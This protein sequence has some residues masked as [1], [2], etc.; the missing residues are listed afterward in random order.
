MWRAKRASGIVLILAWSVLGVLP[1]GV[2]PVRA[3]PP[4]T[5]W[6]G[7]DA[8]DAAF[9]C[10]DRPA[11][12]E[13]T[14]NAVRVP[15]RD[16]GSPG[17]VY[18][19]CDLYRPALPG[20]GGTHYPN[21]PGL[22]HGT[23]TPAA[24]RFPGI[25]SYGAYALSHK[26]DDSPALRLF[27]HFAEHGY[28]VVNCDSRGT[29][30]SHATAPGQ[31]FEGPLSRT[32]QRDN[33]DLIEWMAEQEWS[34]GRIG[35]LGES[36]YAL[37]TDRVSGA[38]PP[39]LVTTFS[40]ASS[41]SIYFDL[42]Y[43]G[44][45]Y[46]ALC[47]AAGALPMAFSGGT[48]N[49]VPF[50]A[51]TATHPLYDGFWEQIDVMSK[52][53][54]IDIPVLQ[55]NGHMDWLFPGAALENYIGLKPH[56]RGPDAT[57]PW[58]I[59]DPS[60]HGIEEGLEWT[61]TGAPLA[62][63]DHWLM[64]L[65]TAPLPS[66]RATVYQ[67]PVAGADRWE[68]LDDWPPADVDRQRL[69]FTV[70]GG[71]SPDAGPQGEHQ[72]TVGPAD[73]VAG[74]ADNV[75]FTSEPLAED[76]AIAG[77]PQ[78]HLKAELTA[79]DG[80]FVVHLF[81]VDEE[82][83]ESLISGAPYF[84]KASHHVSHEYL[85]PITPGELSD[86]VIPGWQTSYRFEEGHRIRVI[87]SSNYGPAEEPQPRSCSSPSCVDMGVVRIRLGFLIEPAPSGEV[88]V[89]SGN[90]GSYLELPVRTDGSG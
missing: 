37:T 80:I 42:C 70:E 19:Y 69:F 41:R 6:G 47:P 25:V 38:R 84:L 72:Y 31:R 81:D 64:E 28:N 5:Y 55:W 13:A 86:Y 14:V 2:A 46:N 67:M 51:E 16:N 8:P 54:D 32:E 83:T 20:Q 85:S 79:S 71:L 11:Q 40:V 49:T 57:G 65:P 87:I 60:G 68:H 82:G 52:W 34:N 36:Y 7:M 23:G 48:A 76:V 89:M 21:E 43:R 59:A 18:L 26:P 61:A 27:L 22:V 15:M 29:G 4:C 78:I 33:Y 88:T 3:Q 73:T 9:F 17:P 63:M 44:G 30:G 12:Y 39:S 90:R 53:D 35:Q 75:V 58:V 74:S 10:Y 77:S 62:W 1:L 66:S 45:A 56:M 50:I 24:G